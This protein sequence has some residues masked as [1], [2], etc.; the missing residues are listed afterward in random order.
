MS[1]FTFPDPNQFTG[2]LFEKLKNHPK[3]I[4]FVDGED[5]RVV[6]VAGRMLDLGIGIPILLGNRERI[7]AM[8]KDEGVSCEFP[9][10]D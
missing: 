7:M 5:V 6:R 4:V 2:P 9:A 3:R 10:R 8:V 1:Q